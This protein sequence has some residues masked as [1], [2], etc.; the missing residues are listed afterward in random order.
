[1]KSYSKESVQS[2]R[3][4]IFCFRLCTWLAMIYFMY[5]VFN[6]FHYNFSAANK[7]KKL[8]KIIYSLKLGLFVHHLSSQIYAAWRLFYLVQQ[9]QSYL[10]MWVTVLI[11]VSSMQL[12][13]QQH[14]SRISLFFIMLTVIMKTHYLCFKLVKFVTKK[15]HNYAVNLNHFISMFLET[16]KL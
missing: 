11:W 2:H 8:I 9:F 16:L 6:I 15:R 5:L 12:N 1:M 3:L 14:C 13:S 4:E 10:R 7:L